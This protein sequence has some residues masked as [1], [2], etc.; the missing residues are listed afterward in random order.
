MSFSKVTLVGG[1]GFIGRHLQKR[2][3]RK[4]LE[5]SVVGAGD[6]T[7]MDTS[8]GLVVWAAGYTK[9]YAARPDLTVAAHAGD[10]AKLV[11]RAGY[12]ALVYLSSTRLYD[13]LEG[14]V[15][16]DTPLALGSSA[17]RHLFDLSKALGEHLVR[18][19]GGPRAHVARLSGVYANE[20]DGGSFVEEMMA[21]ALSG[22]GKE[23]ET[24]P[25]AARDYI[26]MDD[27]AEA[28]WAIG[29]RGMHPVY[30]VASGELVDN[31]VLL[32]LLSERAG[33]PIFPALPPS[34]Q[35][36]PLI[37]ITRMKQTLDVHPM[38]F[39]EGLDRVMVHQ[40]N[41]KAMQSMMGVTKMPW[42]M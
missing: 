4:G 33:V 28:I 11:Q 32:G 25:D 31:R 15:N 20:L 39:S 34:G 7:W 27:V 23:V 17:P 16:E 9:D 22:N 3:S 2:F 41:L 12:E 10:L 40:D 26:H 35:T 19:H 5:V 13:G 8:L 24:P 18:H 21:Q 42:M 14:T 36:F 38:A 29:E 6:E 30:N 37:D 1:H